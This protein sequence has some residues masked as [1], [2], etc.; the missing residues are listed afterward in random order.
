MSKRLSNILNV[1]VRCYSDDEYINAVKNNA[2]AMV[3][4]EGIIIADNGEFTGRSPKDR[5][6]VNN[7]AAIN[8]EWNEINQPVAQE[9]FDSILDK[10][11]EYASEKNMYLQKG[12]AGVDKEHQL[13][14]N[15]LCEKAWQAFFA[16]Q[17]FVRGE[18][19]FNES[20]WTLLVLPDMKLDPEKDGTRSE[21]FIGLDFAKGIVLIIGTSYAGEIK[22]SIFGVM[23]YILPDKGVFPMH[24]SANTDESG[25][26]TL[27]FGLSGT[28]KTTLSMNPKKMLVGDDEHGWNGKGIFNFEGGSYAKID[29]LTEEKDPVIYHLINKGTILENVTI[30]D[31]KLDYED[32]SKTSN[33][34]ACISVDKIETM[35]D[36]YMAG[37]PTAVLFLSA[38]AYGVLPPI[39][40]LT[41]EQAMYYFL[42]GYT[43]KIPGTERGIEEPK[44]IFSECFGSPFMPRA[45]IEYAEMLRDKITAQ[46]IPVYLV[47]TGWYGGKYGTGS[48]I[49]LKHTRRMVEAAV[50]GELD[51]AEFVVDNKFGVQ[52]PTSIEGVPTELLFPEQSWD[53]K[54]AYTETVDSLVE[55]FKSNFERFAHLDGAEEIIKG[56]PKG[57]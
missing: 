39:S 2:E 48:R 37:Q 26:T 20:D 35:K 54:S 34:R 10:A 36:D 29:G 56:Q 9:Q 41:K 5:F 18:A 38:D 51:N 15:V 24:C 28:G 42:S 27:F 8:V 46:D 7:E 49:S 17:I 55:L 45:A 3:N 30:N 25:K 43:S 16:K 11:V 57:A 22:K 14:L 1:A 50:E 52:I 31:G 23:N 4:D 13:T 6:I 19:D 40:K 33:L 12:Y 32:T 47:N 53:D 21:V 44:M